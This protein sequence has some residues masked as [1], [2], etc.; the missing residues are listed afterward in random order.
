MSPD[1]S[2]S[3]SI[4]PVK[5]P[6]LPTTMPLSPWAIDSLPI[7][8]PINLTTSGVNSFSTIPRISYALK[9]ELVISIKI[10]DKISVISI[11]SKNDFRK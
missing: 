8:M 11:L 6:S 9:I 2:D 7:A 4:G 1:I 10:V 5:R 3:D